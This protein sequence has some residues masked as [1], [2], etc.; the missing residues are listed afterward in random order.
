ML[1]AYLVDLI[2]L[3]ETSKGNVEALIKVAAE[4]AITHSKLEALKGEHAYLQQRV[5][6]DLLNIR[7]VVGR[8]QSFWLPISDSLENFKIDFSGGV[9]EAITGFAYLLP[10]LFILLP[11]IL[12]MRAIWRK[13][14]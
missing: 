6:L 13:I 14:R 8:K 9:S 1:E 5:D 2:D 7:F 12:L 10:W 4:I 3:K 11:L